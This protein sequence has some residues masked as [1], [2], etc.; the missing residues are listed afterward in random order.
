MA[1]SNDTTVRFK[2]DIMGLDKLL[3][4]AKHRCRRQSGR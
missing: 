1:G 4:F 2:A 3:L